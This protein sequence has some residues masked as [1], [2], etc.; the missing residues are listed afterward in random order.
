MFVTSNALLAK[1]RDLVVRGLQGIA[2]STR[3]AQINPFAAAPRNYD[4]ESL[5]APTG[6]PA[7]AL[8]NDVHAIEKTLSIFKQ[9]NDGH[10]W[11][12]MTEAGWNK[13]I[14]LAGPEFDLKPQD[15]K[16]ADFFNGSLI[17][18]VNKVDIATLAETGRQNPRRRNDLPLSPARPED[19]S[20]A[21]GVGGRADL[22]HLVG[23]G[24][25]LARR[26]ARRRDGE[27]VSVVG[28]SGCGK[29]SLLNDPRPGARAPRRSASAA[30]PID[31]PAR[32][33]GVVFQ[34]P[35]LLPWR[36]IAAERAAA[37]RIMQL[38]RRATT[39]RAHALLKLVGLAASRSSTRT[40]SPAACSSA[41]D[42]RALVHDP[43][44]CSWT[45]RSGRST[46]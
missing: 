39:E 15:T 19:Q 44:C 41:P 40:S 46:R 25:S 30:R 14:A 45:S 8:R 36:T 4:G 18:D 13:L 3:F 7:Q 24:R 22:S 20:C 34:A 38:D 32:D 16:F 33:V 9:P 42:L 10:K 26:F 23:T 2:L 5:Q 29:S 37:G 6:D 11:G 1:N 27:F 17:D 28:P 21:R 31:G 12:E 35:V 43:S